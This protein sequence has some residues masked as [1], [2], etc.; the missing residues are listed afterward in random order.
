MREEDAERLFELLEG[1]GLS[2]TEFRAAIRERVGLE[3]EGLLRAY[4]VWEKES[5][6]LAGTIRLVYREDW[7]EIGIWLGRE[8]QG[9]GL[10]GE[11]IEQVKRIGFGELGL[12]RIEARIA[13]GNQASQRAFANC[14]FQ[15]RERRERA[16][17][18]RGQWQDLLV[19]EARRSDLDGV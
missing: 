19:W 11:A 5:G 1:T 10:G 8:F 6:S 12:S 18:E 9:R 7:G 13:A 17:L 14:G 3:E 15:L 4:T 2:E 16:V